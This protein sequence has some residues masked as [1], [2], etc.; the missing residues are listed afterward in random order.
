VKTPIT[1]G[2]EFERR[3]TECGA[4]GLELLELAPSSK[5]DG[6]LYE[7]CRNPR[8]NLQCSC[9]ARVPTCRHMREYLE[10]NAMPETPGYYWWRL[11]VD[12]PEGGVVVL[13]DDGTCWFSGTDATFP[14]DRM[15]E[16][17]IFGPMIARPPDF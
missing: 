16:T 4:R 7:V 6:T 13:V 2:G 3:R 8:G 1:S 10:R 17:G 9:P 12:G 5:D 11:R 14:V 15:A